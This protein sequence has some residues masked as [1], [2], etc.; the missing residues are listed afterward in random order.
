MLERG[1]ILERSNVIEMAVSNKSL[2]K[3]R[4]LW[5]NR[6]TSTSRLKVGIHGATLS[7]ATRMNMGKSSVIV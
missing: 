6:Y 5:A 7:H 3:I 4:F 2:F 1:H